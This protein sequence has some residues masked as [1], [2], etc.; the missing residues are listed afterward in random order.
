M[1]TRIATLR[2]TAESTS[3]ANETFDGALRRV[4]RDPQLARDHFITA[5]EQRG[6]AQVTRAMHERPEEFGALV[7][8]EQRRAF[9][10][11]RVADDT[12][13]RA[14][15]IL[16]ARAGHLA[17]EAGNALQVEVTRARATRTEDEKWG[18][19]RALYDNPVRARAAFDHL[20]TEHGAADAL[21]RIRESGDEL[22]SMRAA[23]QNDPARIA[24][25]VETIARAALKTEPGREPLTAASPVADAR[26][27][28]AATSATIRQVSERE[29][30]ICREVK[31]V[32]DR[33][34][35]E[36]RIIGLLERLSPTEVRRLQSLLTPP[37]LAIAARL[38]GTLRDALLG[39]EDTP[40]R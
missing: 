27:E 15:A 20:I 12:T 24:S 36:R 14:A 30:T 25:H 17:W 40:E 6:I 26:L 29:S 21:R 8:I 4:Y 2:Q 39:R 35:L 11:A 5:A 19:L 13:A 3:R 16:A 1:R 9:G 33:A 28:L 31:N 22:G 18:A 38:K 10:L 32:P 7:S 37:Q 34:D 23:M